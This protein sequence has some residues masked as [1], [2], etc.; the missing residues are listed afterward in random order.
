MNFAALVAIAAITVTQMLRARDNTSGQAFSDTFDPDEKPLLLA[1][2]N[3]YG[4]QTPTT[5]QKNRDPPDPLAFSTWVIARPGGWAGY[6]S[7]LGPATLSC[8][9]RRYNEIKYGAGK[10]AGTL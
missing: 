9:L 7:K 1:L 4:G 6:C 10:S 2:C 3:D 8:G 5:G